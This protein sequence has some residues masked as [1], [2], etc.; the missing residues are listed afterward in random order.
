MNDS[1]FYLMLI[2]AIIFGFITHSK[3]VKYKRNPLIWFFAGFSFGAL[4]LLAFYLTKPASISTSNLTKQVNPSAPKKFK[5][6]LGAWYYAE[7]GTP[8]GPVSSSYIQK[9]LEDKQ[10]HIDTLVW[11][12]SMDNWAK[13]ETVLE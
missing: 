9:L 12:V 3:A 11:H 5:S 1:Q 8:Q 2:G 6:P 10:I 13:L 4:G 7:N